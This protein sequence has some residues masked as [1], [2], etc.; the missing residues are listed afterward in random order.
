MSI[1]VPTTEALIRSP[2]S[3]RRAVGS[4]V[5]LMLL[6][7]SASALPGAA[8]PRDQ[9]APAEG[10]EAFVGL[11]ARGE[12]LSGVSWVNFNSADDKPANGKP[13]KIKSGGKLTDDPLP[14][15]PPEGWQEYVQE[16]YKAYSVWLPKSGRKLLQTE[17]VM[18]LKTLKVGY[19]VLRCDIDDDI[20]LNIQRFIIPLSK[21]ETLDAQTVIEIFRDA[22]M[23][24]VEGTITQEFDLMLGKMPGK[25]YRVDLKDG[26]KS[27]VRIYQTGRAVWRIWATGTKE[28]VMG[29]TTKLI[30]SSFKNQLLIKEQ[31]PK[32]P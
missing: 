16:K 31:T 18:D 17:G 14:E 32:K 24:E 29:D 23:K 19:V 22:H 2:R 12:E 27:R 28:Q 25:E 10:K 7:F 13:Q 15:K 4:V 9:P 1:I 11:P 6:G 20:N 26:D 30:F 21:G 5:V 3:S 8:Q